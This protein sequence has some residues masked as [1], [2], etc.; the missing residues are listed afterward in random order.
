MALIK[1][2]EKIEII[3]EDKIYIATAKNG[4]TSISSKGNSWSGALLNV[5]REWFVLY[6]K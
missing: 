3:K 1:E 6:N 5:V 2:I 4:D